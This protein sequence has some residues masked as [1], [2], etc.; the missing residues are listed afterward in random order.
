MN[1]CLFSVLFG[2]EQIS[3]SALGQSFSRFLREN[4]GKDLSSLWLFSSPPPLPLSFFF[5]RR[6]QFSFNLCYEYILS[7]M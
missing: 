5:F 1:S 6:T 7:P 3:T 2:N 4:L